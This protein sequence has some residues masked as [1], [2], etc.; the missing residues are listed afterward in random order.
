M[1]MHNYHALRI[2]D[3]SSGKVPTIACDDARGRT[4][5][6][7]ATHACVEDDHDHVYVPTTREII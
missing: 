7:I 3:S 6:V 2:I 1:S 4:P 5:I